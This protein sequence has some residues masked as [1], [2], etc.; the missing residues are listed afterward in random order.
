MFPEVT[1]QSDGVAG[2]LVS[3]FFKVAADA[4][5][6]SLLVRASSVNCK[7]RGKK[8]NALFPASQITHILSNQT[9][10]LAN[11]HTNNQDRDI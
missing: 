6:V 2:T 7:Q 8:S 9:L 3:A 10:K 4:V 1:C 5:R 11:T